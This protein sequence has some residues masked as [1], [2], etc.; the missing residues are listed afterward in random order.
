MDFVL[1]AAELLERVQ[2]KLGTDSGTLIEAYRSDY[3]KASPWDLLMLISTDYPR[4]IYPKELARR[5][6]ALGKAEAYVYRFDWEL[7]DEVKSPHALE[8]PFV[9]ANTG[10]SNWTRDHPGHPH[11]LSKKMSAAWAAFARTGNPNTTGLPEWRPYEADKRS[12]MIFNNPS[13]AEE[14]PNRRSRI[15]MEKVLGFS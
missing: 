5:K 4:G 10:T 9:F 3:P 2:Q 1:S 11:E 7:N 6:A 15:A 12:T 14:D 8:I 13:R